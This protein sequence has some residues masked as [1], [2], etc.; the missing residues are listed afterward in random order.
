MN[1]LRAVIEDDAKQVKY[2]LDHGSNPNMIED[3][4]QITPLHF[5]AQKILLILKAL[6]ISLVWMFNEMLDL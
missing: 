6:S 3:D 2:L 5:A 1:F 4:A